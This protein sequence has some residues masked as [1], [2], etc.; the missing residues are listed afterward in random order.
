MQTQITIGYKQLLNLAFLLPSEEK[1][2]LIS[3]LQK[4]IETKNERKF[5][6]YNGQGW[7]SDDFNEPIDDFKEYMP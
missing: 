3:D 5:G 1:Q 4:S 6:E 7:I 2:M